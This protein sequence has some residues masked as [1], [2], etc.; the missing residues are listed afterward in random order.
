MDAEL[1]THLEGM[2]RRVGQRMDALETRVGERIDRVGGR[3]DVL[4]RRV[5]ERTDALSDRFAN[6]A[7]EIG[8][9]RR[10]M[11]ENFDRI[12]ADLNR[13]GEMLS[14]SA[15][16]RSSIVMR[17]RQLPCSQTADFRKHFWREMFRWD[18][19]GCG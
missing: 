16:S 13:Q 9:M 14:V 11:R 6:L 4:E 1:K 15:L 10:E 2:E 8:V 3:V 5:G 17:H 12:D 19:N 7:G 18:D